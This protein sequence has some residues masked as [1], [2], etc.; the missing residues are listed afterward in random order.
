MI[1]EHPALAFVLLT[2]GMCTGYFLHGLIERC[3]DALVRWVRR[4]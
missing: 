2:V 3:S 4:R 1:T